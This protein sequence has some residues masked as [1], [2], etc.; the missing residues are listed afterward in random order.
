MPLIKRLAIAFTHGALALVVV[1]VGIFGGGLAW[2]VYHYPH[3]GQSGLGPFI[4]ATFAA[5]V[6]ALITFIVSYLR[7]RS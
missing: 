2:E 7:Q 5:P 4:V 3:D 1:F 6:A